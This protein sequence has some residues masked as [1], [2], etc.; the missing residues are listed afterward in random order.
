MS[1]ESNKSIR[2]HLHDFLGWLDIEKGLS[3][4]TQENYSRFLKKFFDWLDSKKLS[5]LKPHEL[6]PE[7]IW[8][9]RIFLARQTRSLH[10]QKPLKKATQNFYLIALRSL[11]NYFAERDILSLPSEKIKLAREKDE[12]GVSFLNLEQIEKLFAGPDTTSRQGLRDRSI[13][14][15]FFS[16]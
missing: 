14:E 4:K 2:E 16:T 7:H 10:S 9:Y 1:H 8:K 12:G 3:S 11:L 6:T 15:V 5:H 13:L